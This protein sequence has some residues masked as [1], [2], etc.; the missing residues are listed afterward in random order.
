MIEIEII[1][2]Q[3]IESSS[4]PLKMRKVFQ[5]PFIF[6]FKILGC[7]RYEFLCGWSQNRDSF[8]FFW[9]TSSDPGLQPQAPIVVWKKQAK[10][11]ILRALDWPWEILRGLINLCFFGQ[12]FPTNNARRPIKCS[13]DADFGLIFLKKQKIA[14]WG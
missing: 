9:P 8:R 13:E 6:N 5:F 7:F 10:I 12:S 4:N 1:T 2:R 14:V 11:R 3:T